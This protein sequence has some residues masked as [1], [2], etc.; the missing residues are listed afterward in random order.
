MATDV[1]ITNEIVAVNNYGGFVAGN[2]ESATVTA[3]GTVT[4]GN[5]ATGGTV[6]ATGTAT[7]GNV[8]TAGTVSATGD[9]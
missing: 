1:T 6:S 8:A 9:C 4:A 7:V 2:V 3:T 5:L